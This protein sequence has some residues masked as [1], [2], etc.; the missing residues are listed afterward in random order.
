MAPP[1][2]EGRPTVLYVVAREEYA[3][4]RPRYTFLLRGNPD[5][6]NYF[7]IFE[8]ESSA[9]DVWLP[10][11]AGPLRW[12][13][14]NPDDRSE[15]S[16]TEDGEDQTHVGGDAGPAEGSV[17]ADD[18]TVSI[19][20][21]R[22]V[23]GFAG[24]FLATSTR[25]PRGQ[26]EVASQESR[27]GRMAGGLNATIST[28]G[29]PDL[30][31]GDIIRI[32]TAGI[33]DGNYAIQGLSHRASEGEWTTSMRLLNDSLQLDAIHR[34]LQRFFQRTNREE[35]ERREGAGSGVGT[36]TVT[37]ETPET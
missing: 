33:F 3:T 13:D 6:V 26:E 2:A 5:F 32:E 10:R 1:N 22:G 37:A 34:S 30:F 24:R 17:Q 11:G 15:P 35:P 29:I 8:F 4:R 12:A 7:P 21:Q 36:E 25:D 14:V 27:E 18:Q 9:E 31:P 20:G 28:I 19:V 16:G 23:A